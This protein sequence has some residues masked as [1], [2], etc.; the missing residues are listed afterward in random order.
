MSKRDLTAGH[1][2]AAIRTPETIS[3]RYALL[4]QPANT[5]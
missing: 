1:E 4:E 3:L 5:G 2:P